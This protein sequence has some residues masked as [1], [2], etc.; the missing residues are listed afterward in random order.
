MICDGIGGECVGGGMT[1]DGDPDGMSNDGA[2]LNIAF[3]M[4]MRL[5]FA[6]MLSCMKFQFRADAPVAIDA[7]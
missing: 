4:P 1:N 7:R 2:G 6:P 3:V 5:Y